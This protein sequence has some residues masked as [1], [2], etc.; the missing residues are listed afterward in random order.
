MKFQGENASF[1]LLIKYFKSCK[2][3]YEKKNRI[4]REKNFL[5]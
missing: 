1:K 3:F 4:N 5:N 2:I